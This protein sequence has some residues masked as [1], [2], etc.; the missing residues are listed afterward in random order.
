MPRGIYKRKKGIISNAKGKHWKLS[1]QSKINIGLG[2]KGKK[3]PW[4]KGKPSNNKGKHWKIKDTSKMHHTAWNKGKKCPQISGNKNYNWKNGCSK[5]KNKYANDW[6]KNLSKERRERYSWTKNKRNRLKNNTIKE[7][8]SHTFN[9][10]KLLKKQYNCTCPCCHN[11]E[12]FIGQKSLYLTEDHIVPLSKGG[13]DLIK[14]IQPLCLRCNNI[15]R[16]NV[17]KY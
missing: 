17:I 15:K 10:W 9:E 3:H 11:P 7:F 13:S 2:H 14:N 16:S 12:P 5:N 6:Y 1:K 4:Q 8:G